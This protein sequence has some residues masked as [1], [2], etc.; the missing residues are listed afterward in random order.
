MFST[1]YN[2]YGKTIYDFLKD[3]G[4]DKE[5]YYQEGY[6]KGLDQGLEDGFEQGIE[7]QK[8]REKI[9]HRT[10]SQH[11]INLKKEGKREYNA[12]LQEGF[13]HGFNIGNIQGI[14]KATTPIVSRKIIEKKEVSKKKARENINS[15]LNLEKEAMIPLTNIN[16]VN[17]L[18]EKIYQ[19]EIEGKKDI[20]DENYFKSDRYDSFIKNDPDKL[21]KMKNKIPNNLKRNIGKEEDP[22]KILTKGVPLG[23]KAIIYPSLKLAQEINPTK[24]SNENIIKNLKTKY[25]YYIQNFKK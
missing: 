13:E 24:F 23:Q 11:I 6:Q 14:A 5:E 19:L 9:Q 3:D 16:S 15:S 18:T 7:T 12:G 8:S 17:E 21:K 20:L 2:I 1:R 25:D 4:L 22:F 10:M